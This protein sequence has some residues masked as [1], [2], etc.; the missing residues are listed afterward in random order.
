MNKKINA[1]VIPGIKAD[2]V[3]IL[4]SSGFLIPV[5]KLMGSSR[6]RELVVDRQIY[7]YFLRERFGWGVLKIALFFNKHHASVVYS[8]KVLNNLRF[9]DRDI[10]LRCK[11]I[12]VYIEKLKNVILNIEQNDS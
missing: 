5:A 1:Y 7:M 2:P 11:K 4:E 9:S 12:D 8:L 6:L 3:T 10:D